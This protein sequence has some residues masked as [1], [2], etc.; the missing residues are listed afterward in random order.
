MKICFYS[1][2]KQTIRRMLAS[3]FNFILHHHHASI[4]MF[5]VR[6]LAFCSSSS[7][8]I[9]KGIQSKTVPERMQKCSYFCRSGTYV[10]V[11]PFGYLRNTV[12]MVS[13]DVFPL[14]FYHP[15]LDVF[16]G[17]H[18][19]TRKHWIYCFRNRKIFMNNSCFFLSIL[20]YIALR[21][22]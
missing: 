13:I 19:H 4:S 10:Y 7:S 17:F 9:R 6:V 16:S 14:P 20:I 21:R 12:P 22:K 18:T 15:S 11:F 5:S 8:N 2:E 1:C 3:F